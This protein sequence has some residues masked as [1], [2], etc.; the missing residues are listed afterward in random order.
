M[1]D[2]KKP[3]PALV[4]AQPPQPTAQPQPTQKQIPVEK[5]LMLYGKSQLQLTASEEETANANRII[6]LLQATVNSLKSDLE[7][8]VAMYNELKAKHPDPEPQLDPGAGQ[9]IGEPAQQAN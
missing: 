5:L 2:E 1:A 9:E 4:P 3:G 7:K 6:G 8:V